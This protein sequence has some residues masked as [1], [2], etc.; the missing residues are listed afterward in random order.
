[1]NCF[2]KLVMGLSAMLIF[3][4]ADAFPKPVVLPG[5]VTS[6]YFD[7]QV[8]AFNYEPNVKVEINAPAVDDFDATKPTALVLYGLPN[9]NTTE[10][11]IGRQL[12]PG[13]DW[14]FAIQHIGAQTRFVREQSPEYNWV[15]V[16][17]EASSKS[18]GNWRKTTE[19]GDAK[20]K[21]LTEYLLDLFKDYQPFVV[22]SGH[23]GGG[24]VP[25][26]IMDAS[27]TIPDYVK[28]IVFL[29]SNYN[30]EAERYG[31]KLT[32]WLKRSDD[33]HLAVI[34]YDDVNALLNGKPFVSATGGTWYRSQVMQQYLQ[35][36]LGWKWKNRDTEEMKMFRT[37]NRQVLFLLKTN[38]KREIYHTVL[39][40]KN[41]FIHSLLFDTK[42]NEKA[43]RFWGEPAYTDYIQPAVEQLPLLRIPPRKENAVGGQEFM[44][45]IE[46]MELDD[47]ESAIF[48]ELTAGNMPDAF[49]RAVVI[50]DTL[51]DAAGKN[52]AVELAVLPD[53]LSVGSDS[54]FVRIPM[55]PGT[56]Q[57][58]ADA[59]GATL[60]TRKMSDLVARHSAVKLMPHPMTPDMT[61][62]TIPVFTEHNRLIEASRDS[63]GM[64]LSALI[65][66]HKKDIVIT[67]R[68]T[69][70]GRVF[71]YG[72]HYPDGKS[73]QPLSG[74]HHDRYVDYSHGVRLFCRY[75]LVD[76]KRYAIDEIL[77]DPE[78]YKLLSDEDGVMEKTFY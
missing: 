75:V 76:G 5:F 31:K 2:R 13:D 30:W 68:L 39:V 53:V 4:V 65:T 38:P 67:N 62:I 33:H 71:I 9:G 21:A 42:H 47:R 57:R 14:H 52:H 72:W 8:A 44:A 19:G 20:L 66:G 34:C 49:R 69:E 18:W 3:G 61:M 64:P 43:Y 25:F 24:N 11:T 17:L 56:A 60:P 77:R 28:R 48:N 7:E 63:V 16:Y 55:L 40:E 35:E 29:D 10:W 58:I 54:D 50:K 1:M 59:L 22:L 15:T 45:K 6:P 78:L 36:N 23:S 41:G 26:A 37:R 73:I 51:C 70:G 46:N 27:E 32:E 12:A 74:V